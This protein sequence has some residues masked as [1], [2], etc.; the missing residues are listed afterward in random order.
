MICPICKYEGDFKPFGLKQRP[1]A[2]CPKCGSLE[3]HRLYYL[4]LKDMGLG[5][6][7]L[8]IA[9]EKCL[10]SF[11]RDKMKSVLHADLSTGQDIQD[12]PYQDNQFD[13]ILCS[14]VLEHVEDDRKAMKEL[15][16]VLSLKG[17]ALLQVP[18]D[19]EITYED[20]SITS[21]AMREI[22]FG[23]HDHLRAYGYDYQDRLEKA[24][25]EVKPHLAV[26]NPEY[27][28][29]RETLFICRK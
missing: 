26:Y 16:R 14:H 20:E 11:F 23:Q 1:N 28:A 22:H 9:P 27:N 24:G 7:M 3:R 15:H 8:H 4:F 10:E 13:F 29:S 17:M 6:S 21:P 19:R 5:F 25:F 2:K 12:L 18:I